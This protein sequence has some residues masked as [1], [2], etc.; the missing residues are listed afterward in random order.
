ME[1]NFVALILAALSTLIV[2]F[3]WYNPKVFGTI[4]MKEAKL[5]QE[6]MKGANMAKIMII[7]L[8]YAF[9]IAFIL[10]MLVIHQFGALGMVGGKV[11]MAK[12]SY[13]AFMADY[14]TAYRTFKHGAFHGFLT[15]LFMVFPL[16]GTSAL[17]ERRSFKYVL[18]TTGFWVVS[19]MIMGGIICMMQ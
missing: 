9:L 5:T 17:Y 12:P 7:T 3:I 18:V 14:G 2:G 13:A 11:E 1:I 8:I 19:M 6:D 4:W 10:Q 15:S 16:I